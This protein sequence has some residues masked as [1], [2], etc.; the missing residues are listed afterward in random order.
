MVNRNRQRQL[1]RAA[2]IAAGKVAKEPKA[3][4]RN[5]PDRF[6]SVIDKC[7]E[8]QLGPEIF[9]KKFGDQA[10]GFYQ[11]GGPGYAGD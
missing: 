4:C 11:P 8:C 2:E 1:E 5:H 9:K 6:C 7:W 10:E 3:R